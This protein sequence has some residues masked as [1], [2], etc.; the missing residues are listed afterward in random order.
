MGCGGVGLNSV[1]GAAFVGAHP[2]IAIDILDR[3]LEA[4]RNFGA[5]HTINGW[6]PTKA[7][8]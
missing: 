8:P 5:T 4:A 7:A 1:Q 3:K 2:I 6:A